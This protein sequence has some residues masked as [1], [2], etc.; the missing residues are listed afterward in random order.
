MVVQLAIDPSDKLLELEHH[1]LDAWLS[2]RVMVLRTNMKTGPNA[3]PESSR[4]TSMH[5]TGSPSTPCQMTHLDRIDE[6]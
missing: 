6:L 3:F 1:T 2:E 4:R 5:A